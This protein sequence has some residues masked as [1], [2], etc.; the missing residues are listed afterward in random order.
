MYY[1]SLK[2]ILI[3]LYG[4]DTISQKINYYLYSNEM[5]I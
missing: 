5:L 2:I 3:Y 4:G 1:N